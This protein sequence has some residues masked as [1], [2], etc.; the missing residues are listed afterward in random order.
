MSSC[1]GRIPVHYFMLAMMHMKLKPLP[2]RPLHV[3]V[4]GGLY[5]CVA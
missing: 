3:S 1:L 4:L 5:G 2:A